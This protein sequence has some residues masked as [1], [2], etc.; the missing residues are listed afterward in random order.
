MANVL[1]MD[2][3]IAVIAAKPKRVGRS[4]LFKGT[5]KVKFCVSWFHRSE[6]RTFEGLAKASNP[7]VSVS[8]RAKLNANL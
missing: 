2:K 4:A 5:A 3:K 1:N 7:T 6:L 8:I